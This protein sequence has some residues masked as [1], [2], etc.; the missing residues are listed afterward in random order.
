MPPCQF[1]N[2]VTAGSLL[3]SPG[4]GGCEDFSCRYVSDSQTNGWTF[5]LSGL[6]YALNAKPGLTTVFFTSGTRWNN[7]AEYPPSTGLEGV[8]SA[9]Y[10]DAGLT[11]AGVEIHD[12]AGWTGVHTPGQTGLHPLETHE[13]CEL[14]IS[15]ALAGQNFVGPV[16]VI[17]GPGFTMRTNNPFPNNSGSIAFEDATATVPGYQFASM[18]WRYPNAWEER[19]AAFK[20]GSCPQ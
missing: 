17:A 7:I 15:W 19:I 6:S 20:M 8:S 10:S 4:D 12:S 3:I 9:T 14:L 2:P 5:A 16:P 11:P 18:R 1:D 13:P